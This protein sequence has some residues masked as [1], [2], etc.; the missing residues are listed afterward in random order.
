MGPYCKFCDQRCFVP[1]VLHNGRSIILATCARGMEHDR[2]ACGQD[3][4]TALNP[5][6]D[7]AEVARLRAEVAELAALAEVV[8]EP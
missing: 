5:V 7:Q 1:R 2:E 4:T 3:H 8:A 6:T